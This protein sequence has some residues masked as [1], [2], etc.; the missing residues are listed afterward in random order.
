M[1]EG[2]ERVLSLKK[3]VFPVSV[4]GGDDMPLYCPS[5]AA[6]LQCFMLLF[7]SPESWKGYEATKIGEQKFF[8]TKKGQFLIVY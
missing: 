7:G 3:H 1:E 6:H 5:R 8:L 4:Q 2:R